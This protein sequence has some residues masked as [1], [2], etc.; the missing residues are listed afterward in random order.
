MSVSFNLCEKQ[1]YKHEPYCAF[2]STL[3]NYQPEE[4]E[5]FDSI[6]VGYF[7]S[8]DFEIYSQTINSTELC[9]ECYTLIEMIQSYT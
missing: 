1:L 4:K 8:C 9:R 5:M 7:L 6:L 3:E 2:M